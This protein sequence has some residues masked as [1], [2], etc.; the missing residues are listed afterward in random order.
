MTAEENN[1]NLETELIHLKNVEWFLSKFKA[2]VKDSG[3]EFS[4]SIC[5]FML[6]FLMAKFELALI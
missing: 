4:S 1:T 6:N 2:L 5:F 3:A